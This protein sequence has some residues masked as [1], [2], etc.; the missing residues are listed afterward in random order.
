MYSID[1]IVKVRHDDGRTEIVP[2][3]MTVELLALELGNMGLTHPVSEDDEPV[4]FER[5]ADMDAEIGQYEDINRPTRKY[6]DQVCF[7]VDEFNYEDDEYIDYEELN[8]RLKEILDRMDAGTF[9]P[10]VKI[11][12][13]RIRN[14]D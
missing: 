4:I 5:F 11:K 12:W 7:A 2:C 13:R 1:M 8:R 9:V 14:D 10:S 3:D 6:C